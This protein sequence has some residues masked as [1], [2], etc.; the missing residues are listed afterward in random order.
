MA[1]QRKYSGDAFRGNPATGSGTYTTE[2]NEGG[3]I[4][5]LRFPTGSS[6]SQPHFMVFYV[7][8]V[9]GGAHEASVKRRQSGDATR[10]STGNTIAAKADAVAAGLKT[11]VGEGMLE[12][13]VDFV[14]SQYVRTNT[15][16]VLPP[17]ENMNVSYSA[18]WGDE[19]FG[20]GTMLTSAM[21]AADAIQSGHGLSGVADNLS[22]KAAYSTMDGVL[23]AGLSSAMTK[24]AN[25]PRKELL[26]KGDVSL[27]TFEYTWKLNPKS[28]AD[29]KAIWDIIQM[30]KY[31]HLPEITTGGLYMQFPNLF[32]IEFFSYGK[33]ND[34]VPTT[35]SCA[36]SNISVNYFA[37]G[38]PSFFE[39]RLNDDGSQTLA[40]NAPT[41][42]ELSMTFM[43]TEPL[44]RNIIDPNNDFTFNLNTKKTDSSGPAYKTK[45]GGIY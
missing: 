40:G 34:W 23:G 43:E 28:A 17:P 20:E 5:N 3:I 35:L 21:A 31:H 9:V 7:N 16:L 25:N 44:T 39:Q 11:I 8:E 24:S 41:A 10:Q 22:K 27:R 15:V 42:I 33:R 30:F 14:V 13:A 38:A 19:S 12:K 32:D 26:F 36:L 4:K 1:E 37:S 6:E 45:L 2:F 18:S 29:S